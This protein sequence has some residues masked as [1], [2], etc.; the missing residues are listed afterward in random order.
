MKRILLDRMLWVCAI[1]LP[2]CV[3][4]AQEQ[5]ALDLRMSRTFGY[6]S[7]SGQIQGTFTLKASGPPDLQRVVFY[8]DTETLGEDDQAPFEL[9]FVTD[10]YPLGYHTIYT[11]GYTA[12]GQELSSNEIRVE[13]VSAEEGWQAAMRFVIP[14]LVIVFG[15]IALSAILSF[16]TSG[17]LKQLPP[18]TPRSYGVAGGAICPRC[19]RPFARHV[20]SMNLVTGKLERC[21]YCG[22]WSIL[23]AR[24]LA[25]LRAAEVAELQAAQGEGLIASDDAEERLRKELDESR[26]HNL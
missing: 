16:A 14:I 1:L 2:F 3:A 10:S 25:E 17:K 20:L 9:R 6:S 11:L 19:Q 23:S 26:Y 21:P 13:F 15:L 12:G 5:P 18:G 22:K 7:G 8:L 4:A 24:P